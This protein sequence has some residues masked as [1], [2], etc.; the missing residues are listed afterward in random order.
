LLPGDNQ[1]AL[2]DAVECLLTDESLYTGCATAARD[3]VVR[4]HGK[5]QIAAQ[6]FS[7]L[8]ALC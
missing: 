3:F 7:L 1:D 8:K 2:R 6:L 5:E 4:F